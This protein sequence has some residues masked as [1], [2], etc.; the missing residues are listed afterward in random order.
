MQRISPEDLEM[1]DE[2]I[3]SCEI[4]LAQASTSDTSKSDGSVHGAY[5]FVTL[6]ATQ[7]GPRSVKLAE[8]LRKCEETK[9]V[10]YWLACLVEQCQ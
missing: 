4:P 5:N 7:D 10:E 8:D 1:I 3:L 2:A 9:N 6:A